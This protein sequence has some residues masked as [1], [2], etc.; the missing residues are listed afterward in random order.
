MIGNLLSD[1]NVIR[2]ETKPLTTNTED[3]FSKLQLKFS[4]TQIPQSKSNFYHYTILEKSEK[5]INSKSSPEI[6][7]ETLPTQAQLNFKISSPLNGQIH[8]KPKISTLLEMNFYQ[9]EFGSFHSN[10]ILPEPIPLN[11][12]CLKNL[13]PL[14]FKQEIHLILNVSQES[15]FQPREPPQKP[16][17]KSEPLSKLELHSKLLPN[18]SINLEIQLRPTLIPAHTH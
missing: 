8:L 17:L 1:S 9:P 3:N 11:P 2:A 16:F 5:N 12:N 14:T 7:Q 18:Y 15:F 4:L 6:P 13:P 10:L